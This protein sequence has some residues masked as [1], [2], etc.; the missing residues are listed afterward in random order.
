M[1]KIIAPVY[2]SVT[3]NNAICQHF[4]ISILY[5][6]Q[7]TQIDKCHWAV[8]TGDGIE[9]QRIWVICPNHTVVVIHLDETKLIDF[10]TL[11]SI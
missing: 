11:F 5:L 9:P 2:S 10:Q 6:P 8:F 7:T 4:K 1:Q 3:Y